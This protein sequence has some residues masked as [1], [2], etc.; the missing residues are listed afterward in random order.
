MLGDNEFPFQRHIENEPAVE[1]KDELKKWQENKEKF[2]EG[3]NR[4]LFNT[5]KQFFVDNYEVEI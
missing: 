1:L 2:E 4:F 3:K 5:S